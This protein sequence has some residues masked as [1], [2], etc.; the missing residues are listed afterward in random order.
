MNFT[1]KL[2]SGLTKDVWIA[3]LPVGTI[4]C[5]RRPQICSNCGENSLKHTTFAGASHCKVS[6]PKNPYGDDLWQPLP[7]K[8]K[9][10]T[11][12]AIC[13]GRGTKA[14]CANCGRTESKHC[15]EGFS[16][17]VMIRPCTPYM[18]PWRN[19]K[20][21]FTG[22]KLLLRPDPSHEGIPQYKPLSCELIGVMDE[23][24]WIEGLL[25]NDEETKAIVNAF[26]DVVLGYVNEACLHEEAKREG[27]ETWTQLDDWIK[28]YY[29]GRPK[30][31]RYEFK[32]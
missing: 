8:Y 16:V 18:T 4:F 1:A 2:P 7:S 23:E 15:H 30:M 27:F 19:G 32:I 9:V 5:T 17:G 13:S 14:I 10:G 21:P 25:L 11:K 24:E 29:G 20:D 6:F 28:D 12:Y 26:K 3:S 22:E 31:W